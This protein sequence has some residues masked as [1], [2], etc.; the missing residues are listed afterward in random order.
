MITGEFL[1]FCGPQQHARQ[2]TE[3]EVEPSSNSRKLASYLAATGTA[4]ILRTLSLKSR[5]TEHLLLAR[6]SRS[7]PHG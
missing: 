6:C 3:S 5:A 1:S 2:P 4:P 7:T